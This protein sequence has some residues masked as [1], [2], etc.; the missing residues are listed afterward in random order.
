MSFANDG[1]SLPEA[2][3]NAF[4]GI[5]VETASEYT[6]G[7]FSSIPKAA[8][9][10]LVK[11]G[12]LKSIVAKNPN[13]PPNA[14]EKIIKAV[15]WNGV[16]E[17][18]GEEQIG[19]VAN[20]VLE[21]M[22]LGDQEFHTPTMQEIGEQFLS[23]ALMGTVISGVSKGYGEI[24]KKKIQ[25]ETP[26]DIKDMADTLGD[27]VENAKTEKTPAE[28]ISDLESIGVETSWLIK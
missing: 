8:R 14:I 19:N 3:L 11:A 5:L 10:G 25:D 7:V 21:K 23:F 1:Q 26:K 18:M 12:I 27:Y 15:G 16:I 22:G 9:N 4:T 13:L 6:G 28:I 17:E 2:T 20:G 24:V